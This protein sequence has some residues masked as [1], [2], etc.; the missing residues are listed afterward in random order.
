MGQ[1]IDLTSQVQ[2]ILPEANGGAGP[3]AGLRFADA[4]TPSG[5]I[6]GSNTTF[7]LAN[8]PSPSFSLLLFL[9]KVLQIQG[10]DYT[11]AGNTI[12]MTA[13]P[14]GSPSFLGWYRYLGFSFAKAFSE[15]MSMSDSVA[16]NTFV[17]A[18]PLGLFDSLLIV[19]AMNYL[20]SPTGY[21]DSFPA[22]SDA[23]VLNLTVERLGLSDQMQ[24]TDFIGYLRTPDSLR[25]TEGLSL[26]DGFAEQLIVQSTP[27][28]ENLSDALSLS[29]LVAFNVP[30][31][32]FS[33]TMNMQDSFAYI[34]IFSKSFSD[35][36]NNWQNVLTIQRLLSLIDSMSMAD[37]FLK[38]LYPVTG[39][40]ADSLVLSDAV[41]L[42][43]P[44]FQSKVLSD[45]NT[46][47]DVYSFQMPPSNMS[48]FD[49]MALS[50]AMVSLVG[51][52]FG[53]Q[54]TVYAPV[55]TDPFTATLTSVWQQLNG[56]TLQ[57]DG[58]TG[59]RETAAGSNGFS[60]IRRT[61]VSYP[62]AQYA[63]VKIVALAS[64][65]TFVAGPLI[66]N[67]VSGTTPG[68]YA[69]QFDSGFQWR[70]SRVSNTGTLTSLNNV[71]G[72][73]PAV[74]DVIRIEN[75]GAGNLTLKKNGTT[76]LTASDG[77]YTSG[78]TGTW[79]GGGTS[80]TIRAGNYEGGPLS[81]GYGLADSVVVQLL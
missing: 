33:E 26:S 39:E 41:A 36:I 13:A 43:M 71:G 52:A 73:A 19:D 57:Y 1:K 64:N 8:P 29:D 7:T 14:S 15:A 11:L 56:G 2:G 75:D 62:T 20:F 28:F 27:L 69:A 40:L 31:N 67:P 4:E 60:A 32:M 51:V 54:E 12:T 35:S 37:S 50:D 68:G 16:F 81:G 34:G 23:I 38:S 70:I 21:G 66:N 63:Q 61:D 55:T 17:S 79:N 78:T 58:S 42:N 48:M 6:N 49:T 30:P 9:N 59:L 53:L 10:T 22:W 77:T 18:I 74:N 80:A 65:N 3:N 25:I 44:V 76:L 5:V 47:K 24:Q 72:S 46:M 45:S